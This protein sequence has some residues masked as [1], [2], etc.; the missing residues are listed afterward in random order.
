MYCQPHIAAVFIFLIRAE[1]NLVAGRSGVLLVR[2][3]LAQGLLR[4]TS[5]PI[6]RR[7]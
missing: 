2:T 5:A 6:V 7:E 1:R 3:G 4:L